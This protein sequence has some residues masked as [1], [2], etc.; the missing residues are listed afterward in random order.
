[1][2]LNGNSGVKGEESCATI[3]TWKR[4]GDHWDARGLVR[5]GFV[6]LG[7]HTGGELYSSGDNKVKRASPIWESPPLAAEKG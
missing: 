4:M 1:L 6:F 5:K 2:V 7:L 3:S